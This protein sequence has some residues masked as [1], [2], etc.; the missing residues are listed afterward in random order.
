VGGGGGA[1][2]GGGG[3]G[4]GGGG[5]GVGGLL[6]RMGLSHLIRAGDILYTILYL[7]SLC[8]TSSAQVIYYALY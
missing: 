3:A 2:V 5:A 6:T 7:Y 4:V 1:G 8:P